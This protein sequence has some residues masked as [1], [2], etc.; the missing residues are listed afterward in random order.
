MTVKRCTTWFPSEIG[1]DTLEEVVRASDYDK[2][3]D[4]AKALKAALTSLVLFTKPTKSNAAA[5][6]NAYQVLGT[7]EKVKNGSSPSPD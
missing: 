1:G 6:N 4:M 7:N 2:L 3:E 5:L